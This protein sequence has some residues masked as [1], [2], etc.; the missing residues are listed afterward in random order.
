VSNKLRI[1]GKIHNA[2]CT[3]LF[4]AINVIFEEIYGV[5]GSPPCNNDAIGYVE[6]HN[7]TD[8][9]PYGVWIATYCG[10]TAPAAFQTSGSVLLVTFTTD[11]SVNNTGFSLNVTEGW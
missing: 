4:Q 9:T 5:A 2:D 7:G 6:W 8:G 10:N 3:H 1:L 11:G